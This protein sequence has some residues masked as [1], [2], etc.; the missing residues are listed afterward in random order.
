MPGCLGSVLINALRF[1]EL[2]SIWEF[3]EENFVND[4][5]APEKKDN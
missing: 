2:S 4:D 1:G 3:S 5:K